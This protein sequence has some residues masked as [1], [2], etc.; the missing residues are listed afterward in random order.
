MPRSDLQGQEAQGAKAF[1]SQTGRAHGRRVRWSG[2]VCF[3]VAWAHVVPR[4]C[5]I[6]GQQPHA[7][8]SSGTSRNPPHGSP[9][10]LCRVGRQCTRDH[11]RGLQHARCC[12]EEGVCPLQIGPSLQSPNPNQKCLQATSHRG[13]LATRPSVISWGAVLCPVGCGGHPTSTHPQLW[14]WPPQVSPDTTRCPLGTQPP[15][16]KP[17]LAVTQMCA[18]WWRRLSPGGVTPGVTRLLGA[19]QI[20]EVPNQL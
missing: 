10:R 14:L 7:L 8:P 1:K 2:N 19:R 12:E 18:S 17:L 4:P 3:H 9:G 20:S 16:W 11:H 13:P 15:G 5:E 6:P